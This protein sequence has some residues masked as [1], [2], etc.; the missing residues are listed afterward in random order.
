[1][2]RYAEAEQ[3]RHLP[4]R[5]AYLQASINMK[6]ENKKLSLKK[7]Q[8]I[9]LNAQQMKSIKGGTDETIDPGDDETGFLSIGHACSAENSCR[10]V[11]SVE[12]CYCCPS[13]RSWCQ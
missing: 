7:V 12:T 2:D 9:E 4:K 13:S 6:L 5:V 11:S 1:M 8:L 3:K 10:R